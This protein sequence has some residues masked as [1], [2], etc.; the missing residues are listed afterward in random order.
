MIT[1]VYAHIL[2]DDRKLNAQ[3]FEAEFYAKPDLRSATPPKS[4]K[5][6]AD[7]QGLIEQLKQ[8][9]ELIA[10]LSELLKPQSA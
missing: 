2:D 1:K 8:S 4:E 10:A 9:P 3:K 6:A 7:L 5:Q